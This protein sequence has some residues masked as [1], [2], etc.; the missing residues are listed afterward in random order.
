MQVQIF[1]A[2]SSP[3]ACSYLLR[4]A[5]S[6]FVSDFPLAASRIPNN[7]YADNYLESFDSI[8]EAQPVSKQLREMFAKAGFRLTQWLSNA[9]Q[10]LSALPASEMSVP[11]S[12]LG[13][14][15]VMQRTL[16][17]LYVAESDSLKIILKP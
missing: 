9:T 11:H 8:E 2:A 13:G 10:I 17:M 16:R 15:S 3:F 12:Q 7:F 5:A 1:G 14:E 4:W 6:D